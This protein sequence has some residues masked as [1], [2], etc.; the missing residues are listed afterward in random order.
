MST[1]EDT[2][3]GRRLAFFQELGSRL[4]PEATST[5]ASTCVGRLEIGYRD[6]WS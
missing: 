2:L 4:L 6:P 5:E 3:A 1:C